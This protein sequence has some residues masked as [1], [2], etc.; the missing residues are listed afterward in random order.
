MTN[1]LKSV[2][3]KY[4]VSNAVVALAYLVFGQASLLLAVPPGNAAAVWL[5]AG[6]ALAAV[7][8]SGSRVLP[9]IFIGG[10]LVQTIS[11]LD[12]SSTEKIISSILIGG[13]VAGGGVL[14]A[15]FG[16]KLVRPILVRDEGLLKER[17]IALFFLLAGPVSCVTSAS[18][19]IATLWLEGILS[20]ADLPL[21][22]STWWIGDSI[23]VL[24]FTPVVFCLY[25]K[26]RHLWKQRINGVAIPLCVL[27]S[28]AFVTFKFSYQQEMEYVEDVFEKNS[29]QFKNELSNSISTHLQSSEDLKAYFDSTANV[30][31]NQFPRYVQPK[32]SRHPEIKALEWIPRILHRDRQAFE[33]RIGS[34]IR[35]RNQEGKM[36]SSPVKEFYFPIEYVEPFEGNENALGFDIRDNPLA[37]KAADIAC[38]SGNVAV[39]DTLKLVQETVAQIAVVFYAPVYKKNRH[40]EDGP[41]CETLLGIAASVF[42]LEN[43]IK[44]IYAKLAHLKIS[45]SLRSDSGMIYSDLPKAE[46]IHSIPSQFQFQRSYKIPVAQQQWEILFSPQPG[47]I[48]HY[49]SWSIWMIIVT[50]FLVSAIS[51]IGLLMLTGRTLR[52][53]EKIHQRTAELKNEV[54]Q[55]KDFATLL[56][57]ENQCLEMITQDYNLSETLDSITARIDEI[58]PETI[59]SILLL[60]ADGKHLR[61]ASAPG[62]PKEYI[63]AIDGGEI[64]PVAG[65]CGTAA[66]LKKQVVVS[67]IAN[68]PLWA[69]YCD[70]ALKFDLK[71]CWSAPIIVSNEKVLGAFA[72]YF[73]TVREPDNSLI[74]LTNRMANIAAI[75]IL[76]KHS[77]EQL[78]F[79][80]NHDALTG[81]VNRREFE[82]RAARL[83]DSVN[84]DNQEHALCYMDLDQF[85]VVN[86]NCGHA[87]GDEML[88]Q[89]SAVLQQVVRKRDTL[90]RMG[91]DEFSVLMEHCTLEQAH[92]VATKL[93]QVIQDYLFS[94][95][96]QSFRV[97]VSIGLV[98]ITRATPTVGDL[99]KEADVACYM[100]K[101]LGRNRIHVYHPED[102]EIAQ[103]HG[104]M[105]WVARVNQ[106][107][108]E[109]RLSLFAQ[110]IEPLDSGKQRH[111]ELLIRMIDEE[112]QI[113]SPGAFLP[114]AERYNL[115][116]KIDTWVIERAFTLLVDNPKFV[117]KT[118]FVSI[119]LSGQ[120]IADNNLLDFITGRLSASGIDGKKICFEITET[121]AISNLRLATLFISTLKGLGCRF[122]LDDFGSGLSSFGYLKNLAVDYLKIDGMFVKDIIDDPIDRAMVKSIN[123]IGQIM[124]MQTIAEFVENDEIKGMLR[125]IGVNYAQGYGIGKPVDFEDLLNSD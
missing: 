92:R 93:H 42:R 107:I 38:S 12:A 116:L 37:L 98:A 121:I 54:G 122:A 80:A 28:L 119:N 109:N 112:G 81:L 86:D 79:Q 6:L 118:G 65:S 111:C 69:N 35:I 62:L 44:N 101:D 17:S 36:V 88:R 125:E 31:A 24:V 83:L 33:Q 2:I 29:I 97:G 30:S 4:I 45:V 14:Q 59:S 9:G 120:S 5:A 1:R 73:K 57:A 11:Y 16:A 25:G 63:E 20:A 10:I 60:D 53:E 39:T 117:E 23:G 100:A 84:K 94:W 40:I 68:D 95:Q 99:L 115:M 105:Q 72:L 8:I 13:V 90:A 113:I 75:A 26:P 56:S 48:S 70:I 3:T 104:E 50:G 52:T 87:A 106:A 76:R 74:D 64:G 110:T 43:E 47:F 49:S 82:R 61:H 27:T 18:I 41:S 91:G 7:I 46:E 89:L 19:G 66:Y 34:E 85:K 78:I 77:E 96:D 15:W 108:E 124:G 55:R 22:W 58:V 51:G 123:E 102:V 103:H 114:A 71:A 67:D 21:A 32:L